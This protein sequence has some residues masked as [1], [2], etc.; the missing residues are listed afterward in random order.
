LG[1]FE[2]GRKS[3]ALLGHRKGEYQPVGLTTPWILNLTGSVSM[4]IA[5]R[6]RAAVFFRSKNTHVFDLQFFLNP[7][8]IT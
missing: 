8:L 1:D 4:L 6:S 3:A 2:F 5:G 7:V